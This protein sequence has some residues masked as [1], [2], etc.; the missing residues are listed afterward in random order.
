VPGRR[1]NHEEQHLLEFWT[2]PPAN[3]RRPLLKQI[4]I[5]SPTNLR[6]IRRLIVPLPYPITAI[7]GRNGV[8][9]ST[10]L[11]LAAL[12]C[13]TPPDWRVF[14]GNTRPRKTPD[15][16]AGYMLS[17]FFHRRRTDPPLDGLRVGSVVMNRGND[18]ELQQQRTGSRWT[19]VVDPGRNRVT[20]TEMQREVDF[21]PMSRVLS[22]GEY[23]ALRS[24]FGGAAAPAIDT[25]T[26]D[27][28]AKLSY[29][30]GRQYDQAETHFIR[31]LGLQ[32][33]RAGETYSGFD[34]GSGECSVITIL[35]RLQNMPV[36]GLLVIEEIELGL[37]AEAQARLVEVLVRICD[38]RKLQVICTTHSEVILDR[39][40]RQARVLIRRNGDQHEAI[41]N[42]STRFA[43]H[44]MTGDVQPELMIYTEDKFAA[45][46]VGE[47]L[48]G[49]NRPRIK[50]IDI[51][52][53][54]TL[55]RQAVAHLRM[56]AQLRSLSVFDGDC[57]TAQ[58][59]GWIRSERGE[60]ND[61]APEWL[62]LPGGGL[63]PERWVLDQMAG[64]YLAELA[65]GLNCTTD[66]AVEH[67][68]AMRV[69]LDAHDSAFVLGRR[70]GL[71]AVQARQYLVHS[72]ARRHPQ[73]DELRARVSNLLD[74]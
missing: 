19:R 30:L 43:V 42:V 73:L 69:E 45:V 64:Q 63:N 1:L 47:A 67:V 11:A 23:G 6:G 39:L 49:L 72:I 40:P 34:M 15:S 14:W 35:S 50:I 26:P 27:Y 12:S 55:A 2:N 4:R 16:R 5:E 32:T 18:I 7:C 74:G 38:A 68:N 66:Q 28:I 10:V 20:L 3:F 31:G 70:T 56:N 71:D 17:D 13:P 65:Q 46:L 52:S 22:S 48:A 41:N 25:L 29:V 60:R 44:E 8:G 36:G 57:T 24:A 62:I 53:N 9:K 59:E 51:G 37:H 54:A 61:L 21:I 33:C 58:V